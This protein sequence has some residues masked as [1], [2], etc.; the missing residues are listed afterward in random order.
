MAE[1]G[2]PASQDL[3]DHAVAALGE[4]K[5]VLLRHHGMCAVG[6]DPEEALGICTLVERV[7]QVYFYAALAGSVPSLPREVVEAEIA[8]YRMR[9][10]LDA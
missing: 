3:A 8:I 7:A 1:Y 5:A 10:G 6:D 2:R 4:R 9:A